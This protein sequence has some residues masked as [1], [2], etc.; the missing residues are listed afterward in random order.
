LGHVLEI[1]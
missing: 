1:V